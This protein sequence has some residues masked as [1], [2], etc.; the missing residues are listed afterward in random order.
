MNFNLIKFDANIFFCVQD[1][2]HRI[3]EEK[4]NKMWNKVKT[5]KKKTNEM[6]DKKNPARRL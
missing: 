3:Y 6:E 1:Q 5:Q 4:N 2:I